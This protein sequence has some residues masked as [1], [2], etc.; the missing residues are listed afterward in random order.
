MNM[1]DQTELAPCPPKCPLCGEEMLPAFLDSD[2]QNSSWLCDLKC[3]EMFGIP[4][5]L[6][7]INS[8]PDLRRIKEMEEFAMKF[9]NWFIRE[10]ADDDILWELHDEAWRLV[11]GKV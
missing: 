4:I 9:H 8:R 5:R 11:K 3:C 6:C 1:N 7:A 2:F 10:D